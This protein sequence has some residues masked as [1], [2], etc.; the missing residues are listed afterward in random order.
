[1]F[2]NVTEVFK[3]P[4]FPLNFNYLLLVVCFF[5]LRYSLYCFLLS[6][7]L[8]L[9]FSSSEVSRDGSMYD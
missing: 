4:H 6:F 1:M 8:G 7:A 5:G 3:E 9:F 2:V